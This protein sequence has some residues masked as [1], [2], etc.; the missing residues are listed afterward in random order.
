[1]RDYDLV[2]RAADAPPADGEA[3][4]DV[5]GWLAMKPVL[6]DGVA[7]SKANVQRRWCVLTTPR[8]DAPL[9]H[10]GG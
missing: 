5:E 3:A 1:M 2:W 6:E 10:G 8:R 9:L 4:T 7:W